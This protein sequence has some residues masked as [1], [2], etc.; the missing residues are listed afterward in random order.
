M[1]TSTHVF[2]LT[3]WAAS[4]VLGSNS[5]CVKDIIFWRLAQKLFPSRCLASRGLCQLLCPCWS[6]R[7]E[8]MCLALGP[9]LSPANS[10]SLCCPYFTDGKTEDQRNDFRL[11]V[12]ERKEAWGGWW[13]WD[14]NP[15]SWESLLS[16][17]IDTISNNQPRCSLTDEWINKLWYI[18]TTE[19]Y[20]AIKKMNLSQF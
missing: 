8:L 20:S 18:Y 6:D 14:K 19:Y 1:C 10:R 11:G 5:S 17:D 2:I 12:R 4:P 9:W 13:T 7:W 15:W 16:F 3:K